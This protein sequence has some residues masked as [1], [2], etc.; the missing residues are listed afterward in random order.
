[1]QAHLVVGWKER[2]DFV[3]WDIRRVRVKLDTGALTSA[4]DAMVHEVRTNPDGSRTAVMEV[5]LFRRKPL[6]SRFVEAPVVGSARVR[7]TGGVVAERLVIET[8]IRLGST[9]KRIRLTVANRGLMLSPVILGRKALA[10]EFLVDASR[11][12]VL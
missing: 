9:T 1:M 7:N 11:K 6:K 4:I 2:V 5:A 10:G 8:T 3:D 12:Y